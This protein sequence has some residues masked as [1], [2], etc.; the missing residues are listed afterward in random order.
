VLI[1]HSWRRREEGKKE[2]RGE[3]GEAPALVSVHVRNKPVKPEVN[4]LT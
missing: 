4:V 1:L 3:I 2:I